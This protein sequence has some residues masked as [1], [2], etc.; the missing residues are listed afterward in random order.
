VIKGSVTSDSGKA[1]QDC[2][3]KISSK[4]YQRVLSFFA[5]GNQNSF[6]KEIPFTVPDSLFISSSHI[7]YGYT[8]IGVYINKAD[9]IAV[10]FVMP[11]APDTLNNIAIHSPPVWVIGDTTFFNANSFKQGDEHKLKDL[12]TKMPG[13][14]IDNSG[15]LLYK[16]EVV[17]KI[18]IGGEQLFADKVKLMLDNFPVYVIKNVQVIKNQTDDPLLKGL[19]NDNKLF[20]NLSLTQKAKL[21]TAFGTGEAGIGTQHKYFINPVIFSIY[22]KAKIAYIGNWNNIGDGIGWKQEDEL[23]SVPI[24]SAEKWM[25]QSDQLQIINDIENRRYINNDQSDNR[26][27]INIPITKKLNSSTEIDFIKDRQRQLTYNYSSLYNGIRFVNR[28]DTASINNNPYSLLLRQNISWNI[29]STKNLTTQISLYHNGNSN[30]SNITFK[31]AG[32]TSFVE[33]TIS[34]NWNSYLFSLTYTRRVTAKRAVK[35]FANMSEH[36]YPQKGKNISTSWP[37]IFQLQD[38]GYDVMDQHLINNTNLATFGWTSITRM[39]KSVLETGILISWLSSS[40]TTDLLITNV[41]GFSPFYPAAYNGHGSYYTS[42]VVGYVR[43]TIQLLKLP[44]SIKG[45]YGFGSSHKVEDSAAGYNHLLYSFNVNN[46][47]RIGTKFLEKFDASYSQHQLEENRLYSILLPNAAYSFHN[48]LNAGLPL[49]T[50]NISY[51]LAFS[52]SPLISFGIY[53]AYNADFSGLSSINYLNQFIQVT[54]DSLTR[55]TLNDFILHLNTNVYSLDNNFH[56]SADVQYNISPRYIQNQSILFKN[57]MKLLFVSGSLLN[58]W[59]N[60][61]FITMN[62]DYT[63][64]GFDLPSS[65]QKQVTQNVSD[66]KASISQRVALN[67]HS[68]ILLSTDYFDKNIFSSHQLSFVLIDAEYNFTIPKSPISFSVR[69]QNIT[70]QTR[71]TYIDNSPLVQNFYEVPLIKRNIFFRF[72]YEL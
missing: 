21:K 72:R 18:M 26:F 34:N 37:S 16:K 42:S 57:K 30:R 6:L 8:I 9:T 27:Q 17:D 40:I 53:A 5:L 62:A 59:G 19:V 36:S 12:I 32:E 51:N 46:Q 56:F 41:K 68:N 24:H 47:S 33:N 70:N 71:Y 25:M 20:V 45:E 4:K 61:Y 48:N 50:L 35:W 60:I 1:L 2:Y 29:N 58:S 38:T 67:K 54:S 64:V 28:F 14:E 55:R 3:I 7:G 52:W 11:L 44:F 39:Q 65:L 49:K 69:L 15:N 23:K 66:I 22:G 43:K 31:Q 63:S 10:N 13:F